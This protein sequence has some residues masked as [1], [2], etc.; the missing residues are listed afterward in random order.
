MPHFIRLHEMIDPGLSDKYSALSSPLLLYT[1]CLVPCP[2]S[3]PPHL[4]SS[5]GL[6]LM[7]K[8]SAR[9]GDSSEEDSLLPGPRTLRRQPSLLRR[10]SMFSRHFSW[11][12]HPF[13]LIPVVLVMSMSRGVTMSPRIQVYKAIACR[14][15]TA[16]DTDSLLELTTAC[17]DAAV[18]ARAAKIQACASVSLPASGLHIDMMP[19]CAAIVT[20]MSV[21]SAIST[22]FWSRLGDTHGR[23]LI[24]CTFLLGALL[25]EAVFVLVMRP[26]SIFGGRHAES[27]ILVGPVIEGF[28]GGLSTFNGVFHAYISDC[29]RHGSR[30]TIFSTVQG[31]VFVGL[32]I[33]PWFGGLFFPPK[34][35]SDGHFFASITLISLT[36]LY[37]IFVCPES[38]IPSPSESTTTPTTPIAKIKSALAL[39]PMQM[40]RRVPVLLHSFMSA[41]LLPVSMFA[42]RRVPGTRRKNWN[43]TYV[44][45]SLFLYIVSTLLHSLSECQKGGIGVGC[46]CA[47]FV[48]HSCRAIRGH[49]AVLAAFHWPA[50]WGVYSAKYLYA[51]H[52]FDWTTAE[53]GYY[54][55]TLWISRAVNLLILLPVLLPWLKPKPTSRT[56]TP[57]AHDIAKELNFDR[58]LAQISLAVD[59]LADSL[60]ALLTSTSQGVF[61]AL[62]CLS[63]FTSGG[64]PALHSLGAICLHACGHSSEAGALFGAMGVLSAVGHIVSPSI[65]ALT[66]GRTV[67]S[68]PEAIF[69]LAAALLFAVVFFLS[70]VSALEEDVTLDESVAA[71]GGG[72]ARESGE[73]SV[74]ARDYAYQAVV[75][76]D[77]EEAERLMASPQESGQR[78]SA[79][80]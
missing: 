54:M 21:L 5:S 7:S 57:N 10:D 76:E 36:I 49:W 69:V 39:S 17:T 55:S 72:R 61:T 3:S 11:D 48:A 67:A 56:G 13:W 68:Y 73:G 27:F 15:L 4:T 14:A 25:M 6:T 35:Y 70:R 32:A 16:S 30:S 9:D 37:V 74:R 77:V 75:P 23:K 24:L 8:L 2:S 80:A 29:T 66:Y 53:L 52:V 63:S 18:Q 22:G 79:V 65:Y 31:M 42:P 51:Q 41:I 47:I 62:S 64:N 50:G 44:G 43:M 26:N 78:P 28:V 1:P 46:W 19:R 12:A 45:L 71:V 60:V 59:G 38:R 33:G 20:T 34:G 58:H 40:A